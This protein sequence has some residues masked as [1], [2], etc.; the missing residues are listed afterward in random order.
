VVGAGGWR[1][2]RA[3]ISS[4]RVARDLGRLPAGRQGLVERRACS[5]ATQ[6]LSWRGRVEKCFLILI[7][8]IGGLQD[9]STEM[10]G[11]WRRWYS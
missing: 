6:S 11:G 2:L 3:N 1:A 4:Y 8:P 10:V 5:C 7:L 9:A